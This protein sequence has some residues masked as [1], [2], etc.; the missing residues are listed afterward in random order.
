MYVKLKYSLRQGKKKKLAQASGESRAEN[1]SGNWQFRS[2]EREAEREAE[3]ERKRHSWH[4]RRQKLCWHSALAVDSLE[5]FTRTALKYATLFVTF[6]LMATGTSCQ[7]SSKINS[8]SYQNMWCQR[9]RVARGI[10][11]VAVG[12]VAAAPVVVLALSIV[13]LN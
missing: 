3:R 11:A 7:C 1:S 9:S 4:S 5:L 12:L 13:A 10:V 8:Y 2:N 6:S